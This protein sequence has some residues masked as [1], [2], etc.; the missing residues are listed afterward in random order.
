[1]ISENNDS[2][3]LDILKTSCATFL[4]NL[5]TNPKGSDCTCI[6]RQFPVVFIS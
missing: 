6:S 4:C 5:A 3:I 2:A 1:M